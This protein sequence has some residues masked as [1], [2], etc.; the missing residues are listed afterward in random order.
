[1]RTKRKTLAHLI[2]KSALDIIDDLIPEYWTIREYKPD[3]GIDLAIELSQLEAYL[4]Q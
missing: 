4:V 1:M 3:Y 2:D